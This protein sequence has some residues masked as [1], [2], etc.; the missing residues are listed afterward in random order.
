MRGI[1]RRSSSNYCQ[2]QQKVIHSTREA[3]LLA[4]VASR[5]V[6]ELPCTEPHPSLQRVAES[7]LL[8]K[9]CIRIR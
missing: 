6:Q 7:C 8:V 5:G 1:V 3:N 9:P 2:S 4:L